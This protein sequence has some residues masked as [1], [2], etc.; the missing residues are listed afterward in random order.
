M[1][2]EWI[3]VI[4]SAAERGV[5]EELAAAAVDARLAACGQVSGPVTSVYR[6]QGALNRASEWVLTLKTAG[7]LWAPLQQWLATRHPYEVPEIVALPWS[8][9]AP[10]YAAWLRDHL[11]PS[12]ENSQET[13]GR[14][15]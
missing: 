5:L 4:T 15:P 3:L 9:C 2:S 13:P 11:F 1:D 8:G 6:W 7:V 10:S 14:I 12:A